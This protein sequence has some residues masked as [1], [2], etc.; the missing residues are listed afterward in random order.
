[1]VRRRCRS[2]A[3]A[4]SAA[5][6]CAS[7]S[8][9]GATPM[10]PAGDRARPARPLALVRRPR[11]RAA[12][13]LPRARARPARPRR[14]RDDAVLRF[15][16]FVLDLHNL[17]RALRLERPMLDRPLDGRRGRRHTTP[18]ASPTCPP[19][20]VIIE[21]LGPPPPDMDGGGRAGRS[22]ASR[23]ST[24]RSPA[25]PASTDLDAAYRRLRERNPRLTEA[26]GA[27][28][29]AAR[30]ARARG[31]HAR[32]EVRRHARRPWRSTGPFNLEYAMAFWRRIAAPTLIVHGGESGEFWR[33]QARARSTSSPTTCARR[34]AC[35]RD[36]PLRRDRRR[37]PHGALR[38]AARAA[39]RDPRVP[40]RAGAR[41]RSRVDAAPEFA[42]TPRSGPRSVHARLDV[43]VDA[44]AEAVAE[45]D[46]ARAVLATPCAR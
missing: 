27:R 46:A 10:P 38:P 2:T 42:R 34:L 19:R 32:V 11:A 44:G 14:Q 25:T 16:H 18:A 45:H 29:G 36:A 5:A 30:H 22:T 9:T 40:R 3:S 1:M 26:Q 20:V 43:G 39:D 4:S 6:R 28:A 15:G 33:E 24:A 7:T 8:A 41:G 37:R 23:A 13:S 17:V 12:R 31:R 21:G 35:F